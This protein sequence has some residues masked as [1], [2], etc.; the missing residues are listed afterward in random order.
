MGDESFLDDLTGAKF[1]ERIGEYET[2]CGAATIRE[3]P[4]LGSKGKDCY[5]A[6]GMTLALMDCAASCYW[7]CAGGDH[8]LEFL[9]GRA[10]N[11]ACAALSL[12]IRGYYDQALSIARTLGEIA[13][14]L[15]LF[16]GD[17]ATIDQ[18]K[19]A[20]E[21]T[22]KRTFSAV[23][24]RLAIERLGAPLPIDQERYGRLSTFSI[25]QDPDSM[26]Q[27][28]NSHA[29]PITFSVFQPAGFLLGLNEIAIP[30][31]FIA[32]YVGILLDM[33]DETRKVFRDVGRALIESLGGITVTVEGRPWFKLG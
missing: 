28:H 4:N 14:L 29:Q 25:H 32:L 2:D 33:E 19:S 24:V 20:D 31:G 26:P 21:P 13:N 1:I 16:A 10:T 8:R 17:R 23:R 18:W 15:A 9:V 5:Q 7:G 27:A 22:R 12:A 30:V 11:S 3:L 6:L